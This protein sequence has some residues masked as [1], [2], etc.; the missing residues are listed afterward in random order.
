MSYSSIAGAVEL[1]KEIADR[2]ELDLPATLL[3][4]YPSPSE[5]AAFIV[6]SMPPPAL[7][8]IPDTPLSPAPTSSQH[9]AATAGASGSSQAANEENVAAGGTHP[10]WWYMPASQR[11]AW[12]AD[13]VKDVVVRILGKDLENSQPLMMAGLDSLGVSGLSGSLLFPTGCIHYSLMHIQL[14]D[15]QYA[16]HSQ[17]YLQ[18]PVVSFNSSMQLAVH[19]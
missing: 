4:D 17:S 15:T 18:A 5:L 9:L 2:T 12:A 11:V 14:Q 1:R 8:T 13:V 19:T 10:V 3:F 6:S 7:R 16:F